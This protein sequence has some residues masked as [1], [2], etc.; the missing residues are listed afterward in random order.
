MITVIFVI[1]KNSETTP[2]EIT[3]FSHDQVVFL[4]LFAALSKFVQGWLTTAPSPG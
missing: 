1:K 4:R 2:E 3:G